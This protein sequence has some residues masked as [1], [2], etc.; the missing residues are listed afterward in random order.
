[1]NKLLRPAEV[2]GD[3]KTLSNPEVNTT[4][5]SGCSGSNQ[6]LGK[7]AF[8]GGDKIYV[9]HDGLLDIYDGR[10]VQR[11]HFRLDENAG[12]ALLWNG[13]VVTCDTTSKLIFYQ[14][15]DDK[16]EKA[17]QLGSERIFNYQG[18]NLDTIGT[19]T[20]TAWGKY[21]VILS[22]GFNK[23]Q[24]ITYLSFITP[25]I[26]NVEESE[27][28][29]HAI[30]CREGRSA[31]SGEGVLSMFLNCLTVVD[32]VEFT[33]QVDQSGNIY[34]LR[35]DSIC[36]L[37]PN[38]SERFH[39]PY[40]KFNPMGCIMDVKSIHVNGT[41]LMLTLLS[42]SKSKNMLYIYNTDGI[43]LA[44]V[45]LSLC[46]GIVGDKNMAFERHNVQ[47]GGKN[48]VLD[49][50]PVDIG[51]TEHL[52][53]YE[54]PHDMLKS[55]GLDTPVYK[56]KILGWVKDKC[57]V[58]CSPFHMGVSCYFG[59]KEKRIMKSIILATKRAFPTLLIPTDVLVLIVSFVRDFVILE[60]EEWDDMN[61][62]TEYI[63]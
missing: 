47:K 48:Y 1:M 62:L 18:A 50:G 9:A 45:T 37:D 23:L 60:R 27:E 33:P 57:D 52:V 13:Y 17:L 61:A 36:S 7:T 16:F 24:M 63:K 12:V 43:Y 54:Y 10:G 22:Y 21:L 53:V 38:F 15:K 14:M 56:K 39:I 42:R 40:T 55:N 58:Y 26:G 19:Y 46:I 41:K 6:G 34:V 2:E 8:V 30:L 51:A 20:I 3:Y 11:L 31:W 25:V 28:I 59:V 35:T 29:K 44:H 49:V 5:S 32:G 4:L